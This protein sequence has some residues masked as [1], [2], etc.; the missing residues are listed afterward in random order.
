MYGR[1]PSRERH[2]VDIVTNHL[3]QREI[4]PNVYCERGGHFGPQQHHPSSTGQ[5][6]SLLGQP[7]PWAPDLQR[8]SQHP[9]LGGLWICLS[10]LLLFLLGKLDSFFI[11][12][13]VQACVLLQGRLLTA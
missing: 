10:L 8:Q 9:C 5:A 2:S 6:G 4:I 11:W 7:Y 3:L 13:Q 12:P 1:V